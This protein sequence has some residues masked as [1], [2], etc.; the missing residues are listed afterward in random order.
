[1]SG[2]RNALADQYAIWLLGAAEVVQKLKARGDD[3]EADQFEAQVH[4]LA[5]IFAEEVGLFPLARAM[6][7][8]GERIFGTNWR[9]VH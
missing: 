2:T 9:R 4:R 7:R 5:Y 8:T 3:E 1:M 6:G